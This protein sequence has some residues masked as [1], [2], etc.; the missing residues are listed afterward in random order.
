MT[1]SESKRWVAA[2]G[3][4]AR[5]EGQESRDSSRPVV[6]RVHD[7]RPS[8]TRHMLCCCATLR[9]GDSHAHF[10]GTLQHTRAHTHTHGSLWN[11]SLCWAS[12][13]T[14]RPVQSCS[15]AHDQYPPL[16][17]DS[18]QGTP[19]LWRS[20]CCRRSLD[21]QCLARQGPSRRKSL[22][23]T[24]AVRE[25]RVGYQCVLEGYAGAPR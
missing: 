25:R 23:C 13:Q 7:R 9:L 8:A 18:A 5:L 3:K 11:V 22:L 19:W 24:W 15:V 2:Q 21:V 14:A 6:L 16:V 10:P 20:V 4:R 17:H 1:A 12:E